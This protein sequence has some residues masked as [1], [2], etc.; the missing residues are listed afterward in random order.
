MGTTMI[1]TPISLISTR[2]M[3]ATGVRLAPAI[4]RH[5]RLHLRLHLPLL[6]HSRPSRPLSSRRRQPRK[7]R[8]N[9]QVKPKLQR[10]ARRTRTRKT[11]T[12]ER[13]R[14]KTRPRT[15]VPV[16]MERTGRLMQPSVR[17]ARPRRMRKVPPRPMHRPVAGPT[18]TW[19]WGMGTAATGTT[20]MRSTERTKTAGKQTARRQ[21]RFLRA[22]GM[23]LER[24]RRTG[25][26]LTDPSDL[27][28]DDND[29]AIFIF[30]SQLRRHF[31]LAIFE[32]LWPCAQS[33]SCYMS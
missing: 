33:L 24:T 16:P 7:Q 18:M 27:L 15:P 10:T 11:R 21:P 14:P 17:R 13:T 3:R 12:K 29:V 5:L 26:P 4:A 2:A 30:R 23:R 9:R 8:R 31:L 20:G 28:L 32:S 1:S 19:I 25:Q 6:L 22:A